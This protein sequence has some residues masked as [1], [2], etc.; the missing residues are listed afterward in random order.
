MARLPQP[1]SDQ[2]TWGDVLNDYL[3][4]S[5]AA[6]GSLK[7]DSVGGPQLK[8]NAVTA[9]AILDGTITEAKLNTA[10]Q[11]KLNATGSV[12]ADGTITTNKLDS[13][14]QTSLTKAN[15]ALQVAD[16]S[17]KLDTT[18]ATSTYAPLRKPTVILFGDSRTADCS[19]NGGTMDYSTNMSWWDFGQSFRSGGPVLEVIRN[20]GIG[21]NTTAQMLARMQVDVLAYS[22]SYITLWGGTNDPWSSVAEVDNSYARMVQ[23]IDMAHAAGVYVF[24]ISETTA[25]SKGGEF[26]K[27]VAYY[28][29]KLRWYAAN[30][31]DIE[32][33]D[34]NSFVVDPTNINGFNKAV[35]L[36]DGLHLSPFGASTIGKF[37]VAPRLARLSTELTQLTVSQ[38]DSQSISTVSRNIVNNPLMLGTAGVPGSGHTGTLPTGWT[39]SGNVVTFSQVARTDGVGNDIQAVL[40][41]TS[42][43]SVFLNQTITSTRIIPGKKYVIE[44]AL[45][46]VANT[47]LSSVALTCSMYAAG[48][49]EY[50][51]GFGYP[52]QA[53]AAGD[54]MSAGD[55]VVRSRVFT[56]P[57]DVYT[58]VTLILRLG[59]SSSTATATVRL[60]RVSVRQLD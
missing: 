18:T 48:G 20:A 30:N 11:A 1:G 17:G 24:L 22:P 13:T 56:A 50:R 51:R 6:D 58:G 36:R 38:I 27:Y 26:P 57:S 12:I 49:V 7:A 40:S 5:H 35:M 42:T 53:T 37:I 43:S 9:T 21:G 47:N 8:T 25:N 60:G 46:I 15:T 39:S 4:Q 41:A 28:N 14:I 10:V 54:S 32:F 34:F 59:P 23:M 45:S 29:D 33:W 55:L 44:A 2:G 3:S 19:Y 31:V 16:I 52:V